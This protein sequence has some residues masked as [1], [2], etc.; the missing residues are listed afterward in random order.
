MRRGFHRRMQKLEQ[1]REAEDTRP[2][3]VRVR[4]TV[5]DSLSGKSL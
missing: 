3:T 4:L 2:V 1:V 5:E